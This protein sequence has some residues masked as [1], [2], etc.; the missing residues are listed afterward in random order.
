MQRQVSLLRVFEDVVSKPANRIRTMALSLSLF[1]APGPAAPISDLGIGTNKQRGAY[2]EPGSTH[3][4][5][6]RSVALESRNLVEAKCD[7]RIFCE[8][9]I[10]GA[11]RSRRRQNG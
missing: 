3:C 4:C 10:A 8:G 11:A 9:V 6:S 2:G 1:I 7:S 5:E